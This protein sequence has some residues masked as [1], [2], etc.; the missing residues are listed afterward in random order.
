MTQP[1][2]RSEQPAIAPYGAW[3]S[4]ITPD[5][6]VSS[7]IRL[8][9][10]AVDGENVYWVEA[11]P[12][13]QGRHVLVRCPLPEGKPSPWETIDVTPAPFNVR[14]RVHE[15]GGGA[16]AVSGGTV[17]FSH[18]ADNRLYRL[19]PGGEPGPLTPEGTDRYADLIL[20][21]RRNRLVCVQ[22]DHS[23]SEVVNS[24]VSIALDGSGERWPLASG[25]DFYASPRLSPDGT[26][27]AWLTWNHPNMPWDGTELWVGEIEADGAIGRQ[28]RIV[29]GDRE[30]VFQ[31]EWS[32]DNL[33]HFVSDRTGWWNLYRL[34]AGNVEPLWEKKAEF[35]VPQWLF[36]MSTY[37]F[38][39]AGR[40]VCAYTEEGFWRLAVLDTATGGVT[41]VPT[42]F[43]SFEW[44]RATPGRAV[45]VAGSPTEPAS[46]VALD[47][48]TGESTPLRRALAT[49]P[50]PE[51]LSVPEA[52]TFPTGQGQSAHAFFY[53]PR[54][55]DF[56][57]PADELPPLIVLSHGGPTSAAA[58]RLELSLSSPQFWTSR[59]FAVV[60]V[61]YGGSTG[62]GRAYRERLNGQWGVVDVEDC[63]QAAL[64]L[65]A[66][67]VVDR[68]RLAIRG[69]SAGGYTTLSV[70]TFRDGFHAGASYFGVSD[71]EALAQETHKFEA[72]YLDRL[73]GAYPEQQGLYRERSP[74]HFVAQLSC[75]VIFF[76]GL[77]DKVVPPGQ[78][79]TMV[80]ALRAKGV[81]VAYLAFEGEGHGFQRAE[82]I[83][84]CLEAEL[85]FY[86][87]LFGFT[88]A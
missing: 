36:G 15:Y 74:I 42:S 54:N 4:P 2:D 63:L 13:E 85:T 53:P 72:R 28:E 78:A 7:A 64:F 76:Q 25:N 45:C 27:L 19:P 60:D 1:P 18:Y 9:Q 24:L 14:S 30:S 88:P 35:G 16:F 79:E 65:A 21:S 75:P 11:R 87:R 23:G 22:E 43:T 29:G 80:A 32:P 84:R 77:D 8:G 48:A 50:A 68:H 71:L 10:V 51:Y 37:A 58:L 81:P 62:Y 20:D 55:H 67:G 66:R 17:Y 12:Q 46:V 69:G 5:L 57:A 31:P 49:V 52:I 59:G 73:V 56:T 44:V 41:E 40:I 61:N 6:I 86:A 70:L 38:E 83:K 26:R 33:L 47:L 39:S 82:T 3:K 34:R